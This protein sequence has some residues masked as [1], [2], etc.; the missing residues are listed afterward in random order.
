MYLDLFI[1]DFRHDV[2]IPLSEQTGLS[3]FGA[4][5]EDPDFSPD[6]QGVVF[7]RDRTDIWVVDLQTHALTQVTTDG[8]S[9]EESGPRYSPDGGWIAYWVGASESADIYRVDIAHGGAVPEALR[10]TAG[11]QEMYPVYLDGDQ[12]AYT[13]W[14]TATQKDDEVYLFDLATGISTRAAFSSTGAAN[15]SDPF[16]VGGSVI[17]FSSDRSG[18]GGWDLFFG[19]TITG[20]AHWLSIP[21]TGKNDLGGTYTRS[22]VGYAPNEAPADISLSGSCVPENQ[23]AGTVVGILTTTDPNEGDWFTYTLV[24][25]TGSTDN[26]SFTISGDALRTVASFD[27][28]SKSSYSIRVRSTDQGGLWTE[29]QFTISVTDVNEPPTDVTLSGTNVAENEPS[30]TTVGD[31]STTDPDSG[32]TFAYSLVAGPGSTDNNWFAIVGNQLRTAAS[33]DYEA[34]DSY[35]IRVRSTD[36][37]GLWT[38]KQF[39]IGVGNVN[40]APVV[41]DQTLPSLL[42]NSGNGTL[43]GTV[44][45][46][47]PDAGQ[48]L[49]YAITGGNTGGA[50]AINPAT[51]QVTVANQAA[52]DFEMTP[53][54]GL[55]VQ[56][57]DNG[58]P[59][60]SDTATVT[61][62]LTNVNE[63]PTVSLANAVGSLPEDTD[64]SASVKVAEIVVTDD[65]VGTNALS[66]SGPDAA[67]FEVVGDDE[68]HLK[69]GT[70]LDHETNPVLD[71][72]VEVDD[73]AVG[74]ARRHGRPLDHDS[75][76]AGDASRQQVSVL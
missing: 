51:G 73:P 23:R 71:V 35:S 24:P 13:R 52:L 48:T 17:G 42:E 47:D 26:G 68:L 45:A 20:N 5:E 63:P 16:E 40:E 25:G 38:E 46:S 56:V 27:Y 53:V 3:T 57:T 28:E 9:K 76:L 58:S 11:I 36:Q 49:T 74:H 14:T 64:T 67:L 62:N 15:D 65:A 1:Y 69:T 12:L 39:T 44:A 19:D 37:E 61:V 29:K 21:S 59:N 75:Q 72:T 66:L 55:T 2:V 50:F 4:V 70:V 54:F 10:A 60:L 34:K 43:V 22:V 41:D 32:N 7:K 31:L 30:G 33:F 18:H 6:G 8:K